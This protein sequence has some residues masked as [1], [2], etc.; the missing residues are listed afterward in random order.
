[1]QYREQT[2]HKASPYAEQIQWHLHL[3]LPRRA[4]CWLPSPFLASPF[5]PWLPGC[6]ELRSS[7]TARLMPPHHVKCNEAQSLQL[8]QPRDRCGTECHFP[9][10]RIQPSFPR[11]Q[12][13]DVNTA[14]FHCDPWVLCKPCSL[15]SAGVGSSSFLPDPLRQL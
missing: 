9:Q 12:A 1:M 13:D 2:L 8:L 3:N 15:S 4:V 5:P 6:H 14:H 11:K 7:C 10:G